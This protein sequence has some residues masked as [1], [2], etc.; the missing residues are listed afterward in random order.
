MRCRAAVTGSPA[1]QGGDPLVCLRFRVERSGAELPFT[2]RG[3]AACSLACLLDNEAGGG[4]GEAHCLQSH[5]INVLQKHSNNNKKDKP[6]PIITM[7]FTWR[8]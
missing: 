7:V 2:S 8:S 5:T 3:E 1:G 4:W 6:E